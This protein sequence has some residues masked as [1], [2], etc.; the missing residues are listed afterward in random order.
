MFSSELG[1]WRSIVSEMVPEVASL[2]MVTH[3]QAAAQQLWE[4]GWAIRSFS[5]SPPPHAVRRQVGGSGALFGSVTLCF[6]G[7]AWF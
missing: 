3:G 2:G 4:F 5:C 6:S 1:G 7:L